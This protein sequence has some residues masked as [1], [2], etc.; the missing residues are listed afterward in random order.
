MKLFI[1]RDRLSSSFPYFRL[2]FFNVF[3]DQNLTL[4]SDLESKEF[5]TNEFQKKFMLISKEL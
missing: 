4:A 5:R 1:M 2:S 3:F